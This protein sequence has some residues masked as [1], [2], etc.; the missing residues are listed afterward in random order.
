MLNSEQNVE[1]CDATDD[2]SRTAAWFKYIGF[3]IDNSF[4]IRILPFNKPKHLWHYNPG[5]QEK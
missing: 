2:D 4:T 5:A 1:V 3:I